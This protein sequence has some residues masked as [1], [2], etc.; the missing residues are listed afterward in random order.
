LPGPGY[1]VQPTIFSEVKDEMTIA[2]EEIFAPI[3]SILKFKDI[4]EVIQRANNSQFG[5]VAGV[6]T[7]NIQNAFKI[8][9]AIRTGSVYVNCYGVFDA[10]TP[11]GGFKNSGI[12]R[13]HGEY[14]LK[15]YTEVK[16]VIIKK[17]ED[18]LP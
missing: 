9:N 16:T 15:N 17:S 10:G 1:F 6:N 4:D 14:A 2:K 13:E 11:F 18:T 8:S 7:N 12:G 5:L 3:M